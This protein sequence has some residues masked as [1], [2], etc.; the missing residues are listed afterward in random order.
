MVHVFIFFK[1]VLEEQKKAYYIY[2]TTDGP[3]NKQ[4]FLKSYLKMMMKRPVIGPTRTNFAH[5]NLRKELSKVPLS[6]YSIRL[7]PLIENL[8]QELVI[9]D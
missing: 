7:F 3:T 9:K 2:R 8:I 4:I 5:R 1:I 6:H